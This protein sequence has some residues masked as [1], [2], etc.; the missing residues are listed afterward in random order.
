MQ[1]SLSFKHGCE[2]VGDPLE[3]TLNWGTVSN[4]GCGHIQ[5]LWRNI[6]DR[7]FDIVW[8]PLNK[9][10][11][12]LVLQ[13]EHLLVHFLS[14]H[15]TTEHGTSG[16]VFPSLWVTGS[17]H[18]L[19]V[20]HLCGEFC[21]IDFSV[22]RACQWSQWSSPDQEKVETRERYQIDSQFPQVWVKLPYKMLWVFNCRL[23]GTNPNFRICCKK[24]CITW[25]T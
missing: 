17:H 2:L 19:G 10:R 22:I 21:H 16:Q 4:K 7:W 18:V 15:I 25:E 9:V 8:D 3:Q 23:C 12:I 13:V 14:A 24:I 1:E 5:S 20:K 11:R 6:T